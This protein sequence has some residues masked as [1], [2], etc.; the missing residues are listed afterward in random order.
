MSATEAD[1]HRMRKDGTLSAYLRQQ[2]LLGHQRAANN[3]AA[4]KRHPD[5]IQQVRDLGLP[6]WT[7]RVPSA[8]DSTGAIN[9]SPLA[10]RLTA[11][12]AE[13]ERRQNETERHVA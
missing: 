13:A 3:L 6:H 12:V 11:I 9:T 8:R 5:L 10:A 2:M 4:V 1:I 7:G